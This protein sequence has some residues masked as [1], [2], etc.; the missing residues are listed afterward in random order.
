MHSRSLVGI[1]SVLA[2][3]SIIS[4]ASAHNL[5]L[6]IKEVFVTVEGDAVNIRMTY[7]VSAFQKLQIFLFGAMPIKD[8]LVNLTNANIEFEKVNL[9]EAI[10]R[11]YFENEN[12]TK[13]FSGIDLGE[14]VNVYINVSGTTFL[15]E[16]ITKIP[17]FY[18]S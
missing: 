9:E 15:F 14:E 17:A 7:D 11:V 13:Y 10:F 1:L 12:G 3:I 5:D 8:E 16:N 4:V 6:K 18:Y 2:L